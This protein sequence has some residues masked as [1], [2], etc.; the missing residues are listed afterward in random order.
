MLGVSVTLLL[1]LCED[2]AWFKE[3]GIDVKLTSR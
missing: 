2:Y 3:M 1:S